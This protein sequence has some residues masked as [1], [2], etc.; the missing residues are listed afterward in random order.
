MLKWVLIQAKFK[1]N[2]YFVPLGSG[3]KGESIHTYICIHPPLRG[4]QCPNLTTR[5]GPRRMSINPYVHPPRASNVQIWSLRP[6]SNPRGSPKSKSGQIW[7]SGTLGSWV[8]GGPQRPDMG[9]W[10]QI[11]TLD[12]PGGRMDGWMDRFSPVLY[13]TSSPSGPLPC[14]YLT[15]HTRHLLTNIN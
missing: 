10:G 12:T 7:T 1:K 9:L 8:R 14:F 11:C 6:I 13:R 4:L 15:L 2:S 5:C 3:P